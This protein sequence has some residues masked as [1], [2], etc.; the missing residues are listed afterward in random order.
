MGIRASMARWAS[1]GHSGLE[2]VALEQVEAAAGARAGLRGEEGQADAALFHDGPGAPCGPVCE[3]VRPRTR[4][5]LAAQ[6]F[7]PVRA[8]CPSMPR[9][10]PSTPL[11]A[12]R[13]PSRGIEAQM[14]LEGHLGIR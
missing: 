4:A 5:G 11:D 6:S 13:C 10:S 9:E 1:G 8:R 3:A 12:R 2:Q 7:E 14:G